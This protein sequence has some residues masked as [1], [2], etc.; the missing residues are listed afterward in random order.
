[1]QKIN[2]RK[3]I[4]V[5]NLEGFLPFPSDVALEEMGSTQSGYYGHAGRPG[6]EGGSAPSGTVQSETLDPADDP[7]YVDEEEGAPSYK[8]SIAPKPKRGPRNFDALQGDHNMMH[9][10]MDEEFTEWKKQLSGGQVDSLS[11]YADEYYNEINEWNRTHPDQRNWEEVL[12][13][14]EGDLNSSLSRI[15]RNLDSAIVKG[16]LKEDTILFRGID[17][18]PKLQVG[19]TF[20]DRGFVSTSVNRFA[21]EEFAALGGEGSQTMFEIDYSAGLPAA[22]VSTVAGNKGETELLLPRNVEFE[23]VGSS[24]YES[25]EHG[26]MKVYHMKVMEIYDD[27]D[28]EI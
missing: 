20:M 24:M 18:D 22:Y 21:S 16:T 5:I 19:D 23:V 25:G 12:P 14:G 1:M 10:M 7:N 4:N 15:T 9:A 8:D 26:T 28:L 6:K 17:Y 13:E 3:A 2:P 11:L 27:E